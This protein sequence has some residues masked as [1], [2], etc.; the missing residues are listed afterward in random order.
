MDS[1]E[2]LRHAVAMSGKSARQVSRDIGR[3]DTFVSSTLG[4][5]SD[6]GLKTL[7]AVADATGYKLYAE[8]NGE[9]IELG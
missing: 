9:R 1:T 7:T 8:G 5:G 4:K 6:L 2:F 3:A